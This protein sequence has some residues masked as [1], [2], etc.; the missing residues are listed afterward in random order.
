MTDDAARV[1]TIER[2]EASRLPSPS[3]SPEAEN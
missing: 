1:S 2:K 3:D